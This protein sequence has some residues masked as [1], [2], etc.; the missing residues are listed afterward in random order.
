MNAKKLLGISAIVVSFIVVAGCGK[1]ASNDVSPDEEG[2][3]EVT[4]Q[5]ETTSKNS[6]EQCIELMAYAYKAAEYQSKWDNAAFTVRAQK[7]AVLEA[8]YNLNEEE[9]NNICTSLVLNPNFMP[10]VQ[11]RMAELE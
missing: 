3:N 8:K 11:K 9:Y 2:T 5:T 7:I 10:M 6:E 4:N 1:S